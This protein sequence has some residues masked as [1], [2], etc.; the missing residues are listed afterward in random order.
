MTVEE[1]LGSI[2]GTKFACKCTLVILRPNF[3]HR[4]LE[5]VELFNSKMY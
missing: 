2:L 1:K 3:L 4:L 5:W